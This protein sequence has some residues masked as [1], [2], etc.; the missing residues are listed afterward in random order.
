METGQIISFALALLI[1]YGIVIAAKNA[2]M[3]VF[4]GGKGAA[5]FC[6]ACGHEGPTRIRTRGSIWIEVVLWLCFVVPGLVYSIWRGSSRQ[7][8]CAACG[9]EG[10]IPPDSPIALAAKKQLSA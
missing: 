6:P 1:L 10:V 4:R 9:H 8:V 7:P 2:F 5:R 3:N